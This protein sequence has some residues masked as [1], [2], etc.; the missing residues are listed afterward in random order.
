MRQVAGVWLPDRPD[1]VL[2][3]EL[4]NAGGKYQFDKGASGF[5]VEV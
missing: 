2:D 3:K 1:A 4:T 5:R